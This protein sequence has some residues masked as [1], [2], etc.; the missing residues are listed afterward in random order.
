MF[1]IRWLIIFAAISVVVQ[2]ISGDYMCNVTLKAE[3]GVGGKQMYRSRASGGISV[4]LYEGQ[5]ITEIIL[6]HNT[7]DECSLKLQ[8][9]VYSN[10]GISDDVTVSI[11][12]TKLGSF[13]S[14]PRSEQGEG[15]NN[16]QVR[17]GFSTEEKLTDSLY[18]ISLDV[19]QADEYGIEIDT[20]TLLLSCITEV[21]EEDASQK[22][23]P[24]LVTHIIGN[25]GI[26]SATADTTGSEATEATDGSKD[27]NETIISIVLVVF[28]GIALVLGVPSAIYTTRKVYQC[29][30]KKKARET[31]PNTYEEVESEASEY[32]HFC[33]KDTKTLSWP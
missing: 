30:Q 11:N 13:K 24:S 16:F 18:N 8:N 5:T 32:Q 21:A 19:T 22:C 23:P 4:L 20:L 25:D 26:T 17:A 7:N 33:D 14:E 28:G 12:G 6:I 27:T 10:D 15:W 1:T 2:G 31:A 9:V 3:N 29:F